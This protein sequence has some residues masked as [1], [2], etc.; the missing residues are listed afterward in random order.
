MRD[1]GSRN[2]RRSY[3]RDE[4][5]RQH[6]QEPSR[7]QVPHAQ[8]IQQ[9]RVT[10]ELRCPRSRVFFTCYFGQCK[11]T[12]TLFPQCHVN[13]FLYR[14]P[15]SVLTYH[16]PS[17]TFVRALFRPILRSPYFDVACFLV[18]VCVILG[19]KCTGSLTLRCTSCPT[20]TLPALSCLYTC[21]LGG[22]LQEILL[23]GVAEQR[24]ERR[25]S[26]PRLQKAG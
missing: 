23:G 19:S 1:A 11:K 22:K 25:F 20:A 13:R 17:N 26:C 8:D 21:F 24:H 4:V 6:R 2:A 18:S 5:P 12:F 15:T 16:A 7:R 3:L 9:A 14:C 10:P